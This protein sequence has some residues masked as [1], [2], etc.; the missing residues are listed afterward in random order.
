MKIGVDSGPLSEIDAKLVRAA[1]LT[2]RATG[3]P[4]ASHTGNGIAA[5]EEIDLLE[6]AGVPASSFIWVHAQSERDDT[7]HID[8][9]K[10]GAWVEFDGISEASVSRHVDLVRRMKTEGLF[11]RVLS[12]TR[13]R[14]VPRRRGWRRRVPSVRHAVH[15]V[16]SG[17]ESGRLHGP[18]GS[19]AFGRPS[20][21]S[22]ATSPRTTLTAIL[23]F[24]YHTRECVRFRTAPRAAH[25][26][27]HSGRRRSSTSG[28]HIG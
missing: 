25:E 20:Q 13:R 19:A 6:R 1:A 16:C 18:R 17:L 24:R 28:A 10:R 9:G 27:N 4:I 15:Q 21:Q 22:A 23:R 26:Q 7:F 3:L 11:A 14:L 8:A 2:H 12:L 5:R